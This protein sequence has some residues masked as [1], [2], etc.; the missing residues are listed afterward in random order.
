M[1]QPSAAAAVGHD[2]NGTGARASGS[3]DD[4]G[5]NE[6]KTATST[7]WLPIFTFDTHHNGTHTNGTT[8]TKGAYLA[9]E[10]VP[11]ML[12]YHCSS[13]TTDIA[14]AP[15]SSSSAVSLRYATLK[16]DIAGTID[17]TDII[18][19]RPGRFTNAHRLVADTAAHGDRISDLRCLSIH[20][21]D[22]SLSL[23]APCKV[24]YH[25]HLLPPSLF[26]ALFYIATSSRDNSDRDNNCW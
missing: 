13:T 23:I 17:L 4:K 16:G 14:S 15:T 2:H 9:Y 24:R 21:R 1:V 3:G 10:R 18:E 12:S 6:T 26:T 8:D 19:L 5:M 7:R 22:S 20:T 25:I 11:I